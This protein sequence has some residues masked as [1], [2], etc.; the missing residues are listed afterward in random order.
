MG[1]YDKM[2]KICMFKD[3]LEWKISR[4]LKYTSDKN[5]GKQVYAGFC[6]HVIKEEIKY[7]M[8]DIFNI[9]GKFCW[10]IYYT[11]TM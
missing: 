1:L 2:G 4:Y 10:K 8:F 7:F 9:S 6:K 11:L 3:K 5:I